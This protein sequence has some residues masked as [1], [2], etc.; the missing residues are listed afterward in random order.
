M[1]S[2][3]YDTTIAAILSAWLGDDYDPDII[4]S[5]SV[6]WRY[7]YPITYASPPRSK[8]ATA[9]D[10]I[11]VLTAPRY[12]LRDLQ[13]RGVIHINPGDKKGAVDVV[14]KEMME[15]LRAGHSDDTD[16][17]KRRR[18]VVL[19]SGDRD[20]ASDMRSFMQNGFRTVLINDPYTTSDSFVDVFPRD[21]VINWSTLTKACE[22]PV[23]EKGK[24]Y[25]GRFSSSSSSSSSSIN[26]SSKYAQMI[27]ARSKIEYIDDNKKEFRRNRV[28]NN[29]TKV[30]SLEIDMTSLT[31]DLQDYL[32]KSVQKGKDGI[33]LEEQSLKQFG[34]A[35]PEYQN[36]VTFETISS[37]MNDPLGAQIFERRET[38]NGRAS[39]HIRNTLD[40][41]LGANHIPSY[42]SLSKPMG[43][44]SS[45]YSSAPAGQLVS[46]EAAHMDVRPPTPSLSSERR[47]VGKTDATL[48]LTAASVAVSQSVRSAGSLDLTERASTGVV[49][50][51]L[52]VGHGDIKA[53]QLSAMGSDADLRTETVSTTNEIAST[54][55]IQEKKITAPEPSSFFRRGEYMMK[56]RRERRLEGGSTVQ[57][58]KISP[59]AKDLFAFLYTRKSDGQM[60][61]K[62]LIPVFL[63]AYPQYKNGRKH[64]FDYKT[65]SGFVKSSESGTM[66]EWTSTK[67]G[68]Q[69]IRL[70]DPTMIGMFEEG[71]LFFP[72]GRQQ[73]AKL[74]A[75][76]N[77]LAKPKQ[78]WYN[79]RFKAISKLAKALYFY[80][81][82]P[83]ME[84]QG[85]TLTDAGATGFARQFPYWEK[86]VKKNEF[87]EQLVEDPRS[88]GLFVFKRSNRNKKVLQIANFARI[89]EYRATLATTKAADEVYTVSYFIN[90]VATLRRNLLRKLRRRQV[91]LFWATRKRAK[92][93][94]SSLS[95][96]KPRKA[97]AQ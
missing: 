70:R 17:Q 43:S 27:S 72:E 96:L 42:A 31:M 35:Y 84:K 40:R 18:V 90:A 89:D 45:A 20:F 87:L 39:V 65:L 94:K 7:V 33:E 78:T 22:A 52:P 34:A 71:E 92:A 62:H 85:Y 28:Q 88:C 60:L 23:N 15:N 24:S 5:C 21:S 67:S 61:F 91:N 16:A 75:M 73:Y 30:D 53:G 51:S 76:L 81:S 93:I 55:R 19:I 8:Y 56:S 50:D 95:S 29:D 13:T 41:S 80:I 49:I 77:V 6:T 79:L 32:M 82:S 1:G 86:Y 37:L 57:K 48:P 25:I 74:V 4:S 47:D 2:K 97:S 12:V 69:V 64:L 11:G 26:P 10:E 59:F 83:S 14:I 63:E 3:L 36:R 66:F 9:S 54:K 58:H 44:I 46:V 68:K 38:G